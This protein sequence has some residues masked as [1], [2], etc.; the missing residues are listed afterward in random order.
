MIASASLALR[1]MLSPPFRAVLLKSL[2]L[3]IGVLVLLWMALEWLL[4]GWISLPYPWLDTG[5]SVLA[6]I[7]LVVGLG[8]LIAPVTALVAGLFLDDVAE[9]VERTHYPGE[10]AGR[11]MPLARS[12]L[13]TLKFFG[14]VVLVN[15][16]ALPLVLFVGF[17]FVI[18]LAANAYLL[19][20]EYFELAALRFHDDRT[21]RILRIRNSG[22]VFGAGLLIA[23]FLLIPIANILTPLFATA[24]MVHMHK[25]IAAAERRRGSVLGG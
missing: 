17:G 2:A 25:R 15:L 23:F 22:S 4:A 6:G 5:L 19:G 21:A 18:F 14:V 12:L 11:A 8:F 24:L 16:V 1:D 3:T 10:P 7:A 9:V 13:T 20:R